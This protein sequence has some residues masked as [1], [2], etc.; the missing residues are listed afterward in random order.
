MYRACVD[1]LE[2]DQ[3]ASVADHREHTIGTVAWEADIDTIIYD[4]IEN[5]LSSG[6]KK[7]K[8][9]G[10]EKVVWPAV[11]EK[12]VKEPKSLLRN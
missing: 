4:V 12:A 7:K 2:T 11:L 9:N 8:C 1:A 6:K 3:S 10:N 5:M